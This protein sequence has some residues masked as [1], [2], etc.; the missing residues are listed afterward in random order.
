MKPLSI[1]TLLP[2]LVVASPAPVCSQYMSAITSAHALPTVSSFC[3][4]YLG[5]TTS[6]TFVYSH[7]EELEPTLTAIPR[8]AT[9]TKTPKSST[10][11]ITKTITKPDETITTTVGAPDETIT[12]TITTE[13]QPV[14]SMKG[15]HKAFLD[16]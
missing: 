12:T 1:V 15:R 2:A 14:C 9:I 7:Q 13:T 8:W 6:T 11:K 5:I 10:T 4:K 3:S 16:L